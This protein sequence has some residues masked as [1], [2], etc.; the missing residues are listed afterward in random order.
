MKP[1]TS[2]L[3]LHTRDRR[4]P[5]AL[6]YVELHDDE[7]AQT[8]TGFFERGLAFF[9]KH[10]IRPKRLTTDKAFSHVK[11]RSLRELLAYRGIKHLTQPYRPP[12]TEKVERFHQTTARE[13][14]RRPR[15]P[16]TSTAKRRTA[17]LAQPLQHAQTAQLAR[18]RAPIS[19]VHNVRG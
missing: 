4:R 7:T 2:R 9:A 6:A 17:T 15:V 12:T 1:E 8:L 11:N 13:W 18:R 14:G 5:P 16:L 3:R 10:G 19:R